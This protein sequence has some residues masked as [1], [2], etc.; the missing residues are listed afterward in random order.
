MLASIRPYH[1]LISRKDIMPTPSQ[2]MKSK[3]ILL[4]RVSVSIAV[5]KVVR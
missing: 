1:Q 2:P 3:K 4:A 5:R